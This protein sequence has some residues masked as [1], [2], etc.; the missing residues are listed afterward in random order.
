MVSDMLGGQLHDRVTREER[1]FDVELAQLN[2]WYAGHDKA[3]TLELDLPPM[4]MGSAELQAQIDVMLAQL[5]AI[6]KRIQEIATEN[7]L[8]RQDIIALRR[9]SQLD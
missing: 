6:T 2:E 4:A 7:D 1:L 3:E 8:L 5:A 9:A